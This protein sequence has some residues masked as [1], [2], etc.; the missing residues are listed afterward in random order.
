MSADKIVDHRSQPYMSKMRQLFNNLDYNAGVGYTTPREYRK[1]KL[2]IIEK[3]E[4]V[5]TEW[6]L[7][8]SNKE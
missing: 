2:E 5:A 1:N 6:H 3:M 4:G 7:A 8:I